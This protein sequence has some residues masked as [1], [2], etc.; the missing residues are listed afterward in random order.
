MKK[1]IIPL[2]A[3]AMVLTSILWLM[4]SACADTQIKINIDGQNINS[5]EAP[6]IRNSRTLVPVRIISEELGAEVSWNNAERTVFI[7]KGERAVL[8]R[9]DKN[10][11]E[12]TV[13]GVK[14]YD[15][16]D[17]SPQ[18][19]AATT[20]VPIRLISNALG[21][22]IDWDETSR[23]ILIDSAASSSITPFFDMNIA[24]VQS[25]G[26][27]TGTTT[28]RAS[29]PS[30]VPAGAVQ[31]RYMLLSPDTGSGFL[32]AKGSD[33][34]AAYQ[35]LPK[36]RDNG[37]RVLVAALYDQ[38][39][40]FL[41]GSAKP[42]QVGIVPK[43]ALTGLAQNQ[44][45]KG[46]VKLGTNLNFSAA[47]VKYEITNT[48][49]GKT[50][51][52]SE[53][54]P[55]GTWQ[56][57]P[58]MAYN[59]NVTVKAIAFDQK[60]QSYPGQGV[61]VKVQIPR[62]FALTGVKA[63]QTIN[64]PVTLSASRNFD[65][66]QT[67]Y[68][69]RDTKTGTTQSLQKIAYGSYTWFP[70][71]ASNGSKELFVRLTGTDGTV[72]D[73]AK[74]SVYVSGTSKLLLQG[75][76]P[77]QVITTAAPAKLKVTSNVTLSGVKFIMTNTA[78]GTQKVIAAITD[79]SKE[80]TYIPASG[81]GGSWKLK[82]VGTYGTNK[83]ISTEEVNVTVY[84]GKIYPPQPIVEKTGFQSLASKLAVADAKK[85]GMSAALQTAQAILES[86]WGQSV[87]V[88]KYSGI[89]SYNL[90]GIKGTGTAGTVISNTWEEYNGVKYRIDDKFRAYQSISESWADHNK[91]LMTASRYEPYRKVMYDS[92]LGAWALKRCGYATDSKYPVKLID[93]IELYDLDE[94]DRVSI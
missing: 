86:G 4:P 48:D 59:G 33:L 78:T 62:T 1:L 42:V 19:F 80:F 32:V 71:W 69:A 47:Y 54:D 79:A 89:L 37:N 28:L 39:G 70:G 34:A 58:G 5:S 53:Q 92:T 31:I 27:I 14:S 22:A 82:A 23:T 46:A 38:N 17:V 26:T 20:F 8:L 12:Y 83:A 49:N 93:L 35:W 15:L 68:L 76:G 29:L 65:V 6:I 94:L 52:T 81:D 72:Y 57:A 50:M 63:G 2:L 87:P 16:S 90:F 13:D 44:T 3:A 7:T 84:T 25:G 85:S 11:I 41:A 74:I 66:L 51:T 18:I 24:S 56:W 45:V 55:Q 40:K 9:I 30:P 43:A 61:S 10:L 91:L 73:S 77:N 21:V 88:D 64:G 75:A 36:T 67:E 60:K